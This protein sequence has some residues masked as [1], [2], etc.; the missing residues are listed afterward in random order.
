ML[1]GIEGRESVPVP[2][3]GKGVGRINAARRIGEKVGACRSLSLD[4]A[5]ESPS[6]MPFHVPLSLGCLPGSRES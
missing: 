4:G 3:Q 1:Q 2:P 5:I 6:P